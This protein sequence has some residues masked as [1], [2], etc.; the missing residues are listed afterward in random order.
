M[1]DANILILLAFGS[2]ADMAGLAACLVPV[3]NDPSRHSPPRVVA[4]RKV[5]F[6]TRRR[7]A[8]C[9]LVQEGLGILQVARFEAVGEPTID[10]A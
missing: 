8:S 5:Y 4:L 9:Q 7:W 3:E 2:T 1:T 6:S 10:R